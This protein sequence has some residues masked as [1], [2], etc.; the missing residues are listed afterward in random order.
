M[1]NVMDK[2]WLFIMLILYLLISCLPAYKSSVIVEGFVDHK[3][4]TG[5]KG[6]TSYTI[7]LNWPTDGSWIIVKDKEYEKFFMGE[8]NAFVSKST[9]N[10][11]RKKYPDI[12]YIVSIKLDSKDLVNGID[13]GEAITYFVSRDEFNKMKIGDKV[14][15]EVLRSRKYMI[16]RLI[17]IEKNAGCADG[18]NSDNKEQKLVEIS[19]QHPYVKKYIEIHPNA[20]YSIRRVYLTFDGTVYEVDEDWEVKDF[21]NVTGIDGKPVDGKNHYCWVVH[22]SI[23]PPEVGIEHIVDVYIDR[24]SH[25]IVFVEEAW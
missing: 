4:V 10:E 5:V 16:K 8:K 18:S 17:Q 9:E 7:L 22:W 3:I 12:K 24:D 19:I 14:K 21:E 6:D 15:F 23:P 1:I 11:I 20:I 2:K 13:K 25:N